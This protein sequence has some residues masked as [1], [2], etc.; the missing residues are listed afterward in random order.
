M[1]PRRITVVTSE[2]LGRPGTGGAGTADSLLATALGR[3]GH[4]V[5]LLVASGRD[6]GKLSAEWMQRYAGAGVSLRVLERMQGVRPA[7]LAPT[8]EILHALGDRAPDVAIVN[9]WRGLGYAALRTRQLGRGFDRTAFVV[10]CHGP[11]RVLA[12]FAQKVPDT[13]ARFVEEVTERASLELADAVVSPSAWLLDWMRAHGWP[14][15][16]SAQ[17]I[18]YVRQSAAFDESPMRLDAEAPIRRLAFFGQLREGKG[19]RLFLNALTEIADSLS[20][21]ELVFLG[22]AS[23]RWPEERIESAIGPLVRERAAAVTLRTRLDRETALEEL[24]Q[25]GTLAVMPSLL[26]NSPNTVSECIEQGIPFIA[27]ATG[28]IPELVAEDDRARALFEPT[29]AALAEALRRALASRPSFPVA[30]PARGARESLDAW[31]DLVGSIEPS[32]QERSPRPSHVAVVACGDGSAQRAHR[33]AE[34]TSTADVEVVSARSRREGVERTAADW[35]VFLDDEDEPDD[36][37]VDALLAAQAASRADAVTVAVRPADDPGGLQ[38]FL[39]EPGALGLAENQYGVLGVVRRELV[40]SQ[41][42]DAGIADADWPLFARLSL[43]GAR[44]VSIPEPLAT[45]RGAPGRAADVPG[46]GLVVLE[47]FEAA[48]APPP[49]DLPQLAATLAAALARLA[50]SR[51][52]SP[53]AQPGVLRRGL[54]VFRSDGLGGVAR[55]GGRRLT[56]ILRRSRGQRP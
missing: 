17:V 31:L 6:I 45:H 1:S 52:E 18:Q 5:E 9:D 19:I 48:G 54:S 27:A 10:H 36:E 47:A 46:E 22:A 20:G 39:G 43:A 23:A 38:L 13:A 32:P 29:T 34:R 55:R 33:L 8:V 35:I 50:R 21:V 25:P 41:P 16:E 53:S 4:D 30:R 42:L 24:R 2:P 7:A 3:H 15:P 51:V 56:S 12:Q 28:G 14:V 44:I 37:L 40:A 49:P 26:D 11:G